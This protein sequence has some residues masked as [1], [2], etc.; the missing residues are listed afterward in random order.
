MEDTNTFTIYVGKQGEFSFMRTYNL[1][2]K[3]RDIS[4]IAFG[5]DTNGDNVDVKIPSKNLA[6]SV[7]K[8]SFKYWPLSTLG[9]KTGRL[10][11]NINLKI[12][13]V[14]QKKGGS[15]KVCILL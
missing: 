10:S 7:S 6:Y 12:Y 1:D 13:R 5:T 14:S 3:D 11:L 2:Q 9:L 8:N 4:H 15:Q